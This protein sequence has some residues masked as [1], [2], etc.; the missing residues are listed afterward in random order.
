[1]HECNTLSTSNASIHDPSIIISSLPKVSAAKLLKS[2]IYPKPLNKIKS[3]HVFQCLAETKNERMIPLV[4]DLFKD[5]VIDLCDQTLLPRDLNTLVFFLLR[6]HIKEWKMLNLSRCNMGV[7][8]CRVLLEGLFKHGSLAN[9]R[10]DKINLS[11]NQLTLKSLVSLFKLI[12]SWIASEIIITDNDILHDTTGS[13]LYAKIENVFIVSN[14][15]YLRRFLVGSFLF[16]CNL[17]QIFMSDL[18]S[19][20]FHIKSLYLLSCEV[21]KDLYSLCDHLVDIHILDSHIS[22]DFI[23]TNILS[24]SRKIRS[25]FLYDSTLLDERADEIGKLII[26]HFSSGIKLLISKTKVHGILNAISL[27]DELSNLEILNLTTKLDRL[28]FSNGIP[29]VARSLFLTDHKSIALW[30]NNLH[31][32]GNKSEAICQSFVHLLL[33]FKIQFQ[34]KLVEQNTLIAHKIKSEDIKDDIN[35]PLTAVYL[36]DCNLSDTEYESIIINGEGTPL[37]IIYILYSSLKLEILYT[38]LSKYIFALQEVFLHSTCIC[39]K[40]SLCSLLSAIP[41]SSS[42]I[43]TNDTLVLCNPTNKQLSLAL[44][45]EPS[46]TVCTLVNCKLKIDNFYLILWILAAC[47]TNWAE[48]DLKCCN[49]RNVECEVTNEY[50]NMIKSTSSIRKLNFSAMNLTSPITSTISD[51][52]LK[53]NTEEIIINNCD[54]FLHCLIEKLKRAVFTCKSTSKVCLS[55]SCDN[56][57]V[58][59]FNNVKWERSL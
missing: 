50:L 21:S 33:N 52:V 54:K 27:G 5:Q 16:S 25:V 14:N 51:I 39:K 17:N 20:N 43:V 35:K 26:T 4:G 28:Q 6:S 58:C 11:Y 23:F 45:L 12:K 37:L 59:Y 31:F 57:K 10:I 49:I 30:R 38:P 1:M 40:E 53:W 55:V 3:L 44:Q 22:E 29:S 19:N 47:N 24:N 9:I 42:V 18:C 36:S 56:I 7:I 34:L 46:V 41:I 32:Y 8:G 48:V 2:S 13:N 15:T